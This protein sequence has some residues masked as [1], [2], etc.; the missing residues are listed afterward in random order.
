MLAARLTVWLPVVVWAGLI[1]ALSSVPSLDTGLGT[2]DVVLRKCAHAAEYAVLGGLLERALRREP[3][4]ILAG[5]AYAVTDELHQSFVS[6]RQGSPFDWLID[7][8]G[9][10]AGVL[11]VARLAR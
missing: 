10:V 11:L 6:G 7:A 2:W 5:S 9:V 8:V 1:F 3:L 4:A